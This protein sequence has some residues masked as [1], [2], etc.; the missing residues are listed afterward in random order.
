MASV[1]EDP[2]DDLFAN[3]DLTG[4]VPTRPNILFFEGLLPNSGKE[5][6]ENRLI[7]KGK[8]GAFEADTQLAYFFPSNN[9]ENTKKL[10]I[11]FQIKSNCL[12]FFIRDFLNDWLEEIKDCG[13]Y[14]TFSQYMDG[15][16]EIFGNSV[17]GQDFTIVAM[18]WIDKG[19]T[20]YIF[21]DGSDSMEN[22]ASLWMCDKLKRMNANVV[23]VFVDNA[24]KPKFSVCKTCRWEFPGPVSYV[25]EGHG[26]GH[27]DLSC[28]EISEFLVQ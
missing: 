8:C 21:V 1:F 20:F 3:M 23:K 2:A 4:K 10:N 11:G 7:H 15:D 26:M 27:S 13:P 17:F 28:D 18:D 25:I 12:S 14:C 5:I 6:M 19:V 16:K 22:M 9:E 24:S